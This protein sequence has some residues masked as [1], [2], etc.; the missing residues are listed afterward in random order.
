MRR[1]HRVNNRIYESLR[2][3]L[4]TYCRFRYRLHNVHLTCRIVKPFAIAHDFKLG[5]YSFINRWS[6]ICARVT[7]GKYV[8]FG[9]GVTIAGHDHNISDPS[10]PMYFA[11]RPD[12]PATTIGDDVWVGARACLR[13]GVTIGDGAIIGM[14]SVV[15]RDVEPYSIVA[16]VPARHLRWR[17][18]GDAER[19]CHKSMLACDP[20]RFDGFC[21]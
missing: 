2:I 6:W 4:M 18:E 3:A 16:G 1:L 5:P 9:P 7:V 19:E 20:F 14:G 10:L 15:T 17:F 8:M 21:P 12:L 13:A 11:G